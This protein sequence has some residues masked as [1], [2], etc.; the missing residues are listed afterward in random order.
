MSDRAMNFPSQYTINNLE[1]LA[2][3]KTAELSAFVGQDLQLQWPPGGTGKWEFR[4]WEI[5]WFFRAYLDYSL[6]ELRASKGPPSLPRWPNGSP[7]VNFVG[8]LMPLNA[9]TGEAYVH[10]FLDTIQGTVIARLYKQEYLTQFSAAGELV[11]VYGQPADRLL[12]EAPLVRDDC[13]AFAAEGMP[14]T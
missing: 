3:E 5:E 2:R 11:G 1:Q 13:G 6:F 8:D 7:K 12:A 4:S 10:E 9:S 14:S